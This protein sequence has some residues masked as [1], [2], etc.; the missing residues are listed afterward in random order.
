MQNYKVV[1]H[2][3]YRY[4]LQKDAATAAFCCRAR[5]V[6]VKAAPN[7][8]KET[9]QTA[10]ATIGKGEIIVRDNPGQSLE[11]LNRDPAQA[12]KTEPENR[13][14]NQAVRWL[15]RARH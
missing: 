15:I 7:N 1:G 4:L 10:Y 9:T 3:R 12:M 14:V 5:G 11:G 8:Y 6:A 2:I 13:P